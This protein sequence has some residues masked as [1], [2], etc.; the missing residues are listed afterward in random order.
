[1]IDR[2]GFR[3]REHVNAFEPIAVLRAGIREFLP[4]GGA[5]DDARH[6]DLYIGFQHRRRCVM[7]A[8]VGLEQQAA[9]R[10]V[11]QAYETLVRLV[12]GWFFSAGW[13]RR[14]RGDEQEHCSQER[15][16]D[17]RSDSIGKR[18]LSH[19]SPFEEEA[20]GEG[21][22]RLYHSD[23]V[24]LDVKC[25]CEPALARHVP[26]HA[27]AQLGMDLTSGCRFE[28]RNIRVLR[29]GRVGGWEDAVE[30]RA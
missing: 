15:E 7:A 18:A 13:Q 17:E 29:L 3:K 30:Q 19:P 28:G 16:A 6:G 2:G 21:V 4:D 8:L 9:L 11:F 24:L 20:T 23:L 14:H 26:H 12:D 1:M 22:I 5:R 27:S 25:G 10:D